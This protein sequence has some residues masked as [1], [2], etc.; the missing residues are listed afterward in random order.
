MSLVISSLASKGIIPEQ[1]LFAIKISN[2]V[3]S[4]YFIHAVSYWGTMYLLGWFFGLM[5]LRDAGLVGSVD[6]VIYFVVPF[7]YFVKRLFR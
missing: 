6:F 5:F 1:Y 4:I 7:L 3:A 2:L